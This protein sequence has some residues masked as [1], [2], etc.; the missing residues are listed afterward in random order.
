MSAASRIS[1]IYLLLAD[2]DVE[3]VADRGIA[4]A[5][6]QAEWEAVCREMETRFRAGQFEAGVLYGIAEIGRRLQVLYPPAGE[7]ANEL[8]DRPLVL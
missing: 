1:L 8:P 3:I 4:R 7:N 2:R 5:V 6:P